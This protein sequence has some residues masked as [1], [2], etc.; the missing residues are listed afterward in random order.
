MTEALL[1]ALR[2][3][4]DEWLR[5]RWRDLQFSDA[6]TAL[7]VFVVLAA[8]AV[9]VLFARAMLGTRAGR[10]HITLP[11]LLPGMRRSPLALTRHLP[12]ML[13]VAGLPFFGIALA[14]PHTG[15]T[16]EEV[17]HPGRRIA[18]LVDASTSMACSSRRNDEDPGRGHILHGCCRAENVHQTSHEGP[19]RDLVA[20]IQFGNQAYV[21]TPFTTDYENIC[22]ASA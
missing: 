19:Y 9:L 17:S 7:L 8:I 18:L 5:T 10:T 16:R 22:S 13:F 3:T 15:F 20:L 2:S 4:F 14:D 1:I 12:L 21:V 6:R 11:S